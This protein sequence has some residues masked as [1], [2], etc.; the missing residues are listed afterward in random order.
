[1]QSVSGLVLALLGRPA[2]VGDVV[3]WGQ[4]RIEVTTVAGRGVSEAAMTKL[5]ALN[6]GGVAGL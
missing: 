4:V 5:P 3:T 6:A 2:Q 1:V